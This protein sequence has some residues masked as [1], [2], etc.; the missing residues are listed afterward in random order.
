MTDL[1]RKWVG[2]VWKLDGE[3]CVSKL[4]ADHSDGRFGVDHECECGA[5]FVDSVAH[6]WA[7]RTAR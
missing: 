7:E 4:L 5:W 2:P 1:C 3:A 6:D